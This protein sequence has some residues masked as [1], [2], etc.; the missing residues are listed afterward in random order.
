[1]KNKNG[2][3]ILGSNEPLKFGKQPKVVGTRPSQ[4]GRTFKKEVFETIKNIVVNDGVPFEPEEASFRYIYPKEDKFVEDKINEVKRDKN[5]PDLFGPLKKTKLEVWRMVINNVFPHIDIVKVPATVV[6]ILKNYGYIKAKSLEDHT[7]KKFI[8][9]TNELVD[10]ISAGYVYHIAKETDLNPT[11]VISKIEKTIINGKRT[12]SDILDTTYKIQDLINV[13]ENYNLNQLVEDEFNH[14]DIRV[15]YLRCLKFPNL[16]NL[17]LEILESIKDASLN[18]KGLE[19]V[20]IKGGRFKRLPNEE[21]QKGL[22]L[23]NMIKKYGIRYINSRSNLEW[24]FY[25]TTLKK[26]RNF[27]GRDKNSKFMGIILDAIRA[28][29]VEQVNMGESIIGVYP[30][31]EILQK[32]LDKAKSQRDKRFNKDKN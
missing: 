13:V 6:G 1:M 12:H 20:E 31:I 7:L 28:F 24:Y 3:K 11:L 18:I 10:I 21:F 19:A 22:V 30:N 8:P 23:V 26:I 15:K 14:Y 29:N 4:S 5:I 2:F 32:Y 16:D 9:N 25:G 17:L 27:L